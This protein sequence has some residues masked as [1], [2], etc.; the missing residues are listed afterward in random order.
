MRDFLLLCLIIRCAPDE[1]GGASGEV[2]VI[3]DSE[4][5][6]R[7]WN[8]ADDR[9]QTDDYVSVF[10]SEG[11]IIPL[12]QRLQSTVIICDIITGV[13]QREMEAER[14]SGISIWLNELIKK[15]KKSVRG[16]EWMY[17]WLNEWKGNYSLCVCVCVTG[18]NF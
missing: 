10:V 4:E 2:G 12:P 6:A 8:R 14:T 5:M 17:V 7:L 1:V 16:S 9:Q 3:F 18:W 11:V 15:V 13:W